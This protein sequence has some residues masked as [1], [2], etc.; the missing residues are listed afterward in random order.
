MLLCNAVIYHSMWTISVN[1][2]LSL[3]HVRSL[4][5]GEKKKSIWNESEGL[6]IVQSDWG[7]CVRQ[8]SLCL[9]C[10]VAKAL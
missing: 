1:H 5:S 7:A 2:L 3:A 4:N 9:V 6:N 8:S 10:E